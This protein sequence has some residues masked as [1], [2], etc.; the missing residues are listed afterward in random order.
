MFGSDRVSFGYISIVSVL[1]SFKAILVALIICFPNSALSP[2]KG[3][4]SPILILFSF[5]SLFFGFYFNENSAGAGSYD[6]DLKT[7]W[8]NLQIFLVND[9]RSS[10]NHPDYFDSR[11][12]I[13][14]IFHEVF[15]PFA[16][17]ETFFNNSL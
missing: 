1:I 9:L 3:T 8:K 11:T 16:N 7:I 2:L 4:K 12:P 10:I 17:N 14:Y 5:S 6:G 15:N 13:A